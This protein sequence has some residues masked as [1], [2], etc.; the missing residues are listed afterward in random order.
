MPVKVVAFVTVK[1]DADD[2]F[3]AAAMTCAAASR[4]EAGTL[5]YDLWREPEGERRV[6]FNELYVDDAAVKQHMASDHFKAFGKA[7]GDLWAAPPTIIVTHPIDV[8]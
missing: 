6:V 8:A 4:E 2:A 5:R 3:L 1:P 7:A